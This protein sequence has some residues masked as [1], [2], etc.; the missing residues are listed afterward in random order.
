MA[1]KNSDKKSDKPKSKVIAP[2]PVSE[3]AYKSYYDLALLK[4]KEIKEKYDMSKVENSKFS[5]VR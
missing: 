1:K 4:A 3:R 2:A 5:I